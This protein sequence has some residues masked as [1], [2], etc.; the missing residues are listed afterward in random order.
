[1]YPARSKS[2]DRSTLQTTLGAAVAPQSSAAEHPA[3]V[4]TPPPASLPPPV[5]RAPPR[6]ASSKRQ[7]HQYFADR[8]RMKEFPTHPANA[9]YPRYLNVASPAPRP[10]ANAR[11]L[12]DSD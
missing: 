4:A 11:F 8:W 12:P 1:M 6:A 2:A 5:L 10:A 3:D 9:L 7:S